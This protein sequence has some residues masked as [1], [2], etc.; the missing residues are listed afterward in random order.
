[1]ND[2]LMFLQSCVESLV[3]YVAAIHQKTR[4]FAESLRHVLHALEIAV[5][6]A[7]VVL[8]ILFPSGQALPMLLAMLVI[9]ASCSVPPYG[10]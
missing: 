6:W 9:V 10:G 2:W 8:G 3:Q 7:L 4:P 1:M 5:S